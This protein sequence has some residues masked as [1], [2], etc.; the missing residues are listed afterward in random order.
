MQLLFDRN[1]TGFGTETEG[2]CVT[3]AEDGTRTFHIADYNK[4]VTTFIRTYQLT[5]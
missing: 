5:E 2:L 1:T 4:L 3:T